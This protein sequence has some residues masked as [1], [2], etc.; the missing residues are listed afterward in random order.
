MQPRTRAHTH[1]T[2]ASPLR[3]A[4]LAQLF[5]VAIAAA[6]IKLIYP[7]LLALPLAAAAL[8]G[9]CAALASHKLGAPRWWLAI[10]LGFLPAALWLSAW[11]IAP[12]WYLLAFA[13]LASIYWRTDRSQVPLYLS[14]SKT[15]GALAALLPQRPLN[16]ADLGCGDGGLLRRLARL[17]PDCCYVGCEHAPLPWLWAK[18]STLS[19]SNVRICYG[20]FWRRDLGEF[21][22]VY[23]FLSPVPMARLMAK[24]GAEMRPGTLFVSNSF[25]VPGG[26]PGQ[27]VVVDD[28][29]RTQLYCYG[30]ES[31][32]PPGDAAYK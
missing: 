18:L 1:A 15:A 2:P 8:Q 22:V 24:V 30:G 29:R 31:L 5:G 20:D 10:H 9:A 19:H 25:A 12:T 7:Q 26:V 23:A 14:N 27:V 17:R 32:R 13:L 11:D 21:D 3:T 28:R 16:I 6:L 4:V